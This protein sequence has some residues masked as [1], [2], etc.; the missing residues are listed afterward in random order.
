MFKA[1]IQLVAEWPSVTPQTSESELVGWLNELLSCMLVMPDSPE[2]SQ[3]LY[4]FNGL[5]N[6]VNKLAFY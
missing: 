3:P 4:L 6:A 2:H 1:A 5:C